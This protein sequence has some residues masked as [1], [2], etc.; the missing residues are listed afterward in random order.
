MAGAYDKDTVTPTTGLKPNQPGLAYV[1]ND[2]T[3]KWVQPPKPADNR[4][5]T[6]DNNKGWVDSGNVNTLGL[7]TSVGFV[8]S[9]VLITD[10]IYGVDAK[11]AQGNVIPGLKS[12]YD[13]WAAGKETEALDAYFKS[14]WFTKLGKT[15]AERYALDK[16]QHDVYLQELAAYKLAQKQRLVQLGVKI[17][18]PALDGYLE[19][20]YRGVLTDAQVNKLVAKSKDFGQ[21]FSGEVLGVIQDAKE[22]ARA[23]GVAYGE[24]N[25]TQWGKRLFL[26]EITDSEIQENIRQTSASAFPAYRDLLMKGVTM[27][28]ISSAYKQSMANILEIN[29]AAIDVLSDQTLRRA[30]QGS[31]AGAG[32]GEGQIPMTLWQ[33][34]QSLRQDYR[35]QYTNNARESSYNMVNAVLTDFGLKG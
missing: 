10:D 2:A 29:P 24:D 33:F 30:F 22:Y 14:N 15:A 4:I 31:G 35:W 7:T 19:E 16:N 11:D 26:G 17:E 13:L 8:L 9:Q 20:A 1:W 25:Y 28:S 21:N 3:G 18:D 5:Y 23:M 6:W 27:D 34:E 12:V 32:G